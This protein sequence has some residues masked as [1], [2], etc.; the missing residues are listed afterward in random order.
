LAKIVFEKASVE[1]PIFN[2]T[3]RSITSR[4]L[5]L[6]TGGQLDS[7]PHGRVQVRALSEISIELQDGD[8]VGIVGNNGAGKSTLLR[9][10]GGI[11]MPTKG[12]VSISGTV[13]SLIDI[14][15]G[16]NPEATGRENIFIRGQLLGLSKKELLRK[17]D[18]IVSFTEL[19]NF[20][21]L[22]VRT[23]SSG[24]HLRL[25]FAVSTMVQPDILLMDEW[26]SVGDDGFREQAEAR[27]R[28]L[29]SETRI[30]AIA[31][32][33]QQLIKSVCNRAIWLEHGEIKMIGEVDEVLESYFSS[34][35][36]GN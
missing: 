4:F 21:E 27:L 9:A 10:L 28:E 30:L 17:Y 33:S 26:L 12:T 23:Y 16:I 18:E 22:P 35:R 20:I 8:R 24:M 31:S 11:Y 5:E 15:L 2:A 1:I 25:A 7:D 19:G 6:A 13:G 34:E 29:V 14:S 32:H 3:S 36:P